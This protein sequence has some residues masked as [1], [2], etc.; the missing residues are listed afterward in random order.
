MAKTTTITNSFYSGLFEADRENDPEAHSTIIEKLCGEIG[1]NAPWLE[2]AIRMAL[3][4]I[5]VFVQN[6]S[7]EGL[8][9]TKRALFG[10][11]RGS[12]R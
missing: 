4:A 3:P 10:A 9:R 8:E 2:P 5:H 11:V 12:A 1:V 6:T 7:Q